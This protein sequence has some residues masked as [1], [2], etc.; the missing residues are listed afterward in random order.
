[1]P[2]DE[3]IAIE[4]HVREPDRLGED[5]AVLDREIARD[6]LE[7]TAIRRFLTITGV[8]LTVAAG[9]MVAVGSIDR[10]DSPQKLVSYFG[11]NPR[12]RQSGLGAAHHGRI[13]KVGRSHARAMLVEAAWAAAKAPGPLR[14]FFIRVR[15][16]RGHQIAAVAVARKLATLCWHMLTKGEDYRRARP[17]L[18]AHKHRA[19]ELAAGEPQ[20][21]GNRRG[22]SYAYNVKALRR[23]EM[24]IAERAQ[25]SY[26]HFVAAW[27]SRAPSTGRCAAASNRQGLHRLPGDASNRRAT[28]R[29]EVDRTMKE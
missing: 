19:M 9:L 17:S 25:A 16:R 27:R 20:K 4:R 22:A 10:F 23:Q 15:A 11:L 12:V 18:V 29:H 6:A 3:R 13:S 26:E 5:L 2:E 24:Q 8:N 14:A 28:L 7:D 1:M 21:K